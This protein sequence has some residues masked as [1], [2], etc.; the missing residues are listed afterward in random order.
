MVI[1]EAMASGTP[2]VATRVGGIPQ[3]VMDGQTG[4][5]VDSNDLTGLCSAYEK[6]I[7]NE[8]LRKSLVDN[9][10]QFVQ[11]EYSVEQMTNAYS[12]IYREV[13]A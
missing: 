7:S 9:A 2:V 6:L 5:L 1:L 13:L 4:L 12:K 11:K 3:L 10:F 8:A